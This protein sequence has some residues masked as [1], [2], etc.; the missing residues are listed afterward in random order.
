VWFSAFLYSWKNCVS[1]LYATRSFRFPAFIRRF[2]IES[3]QLCLLAM[4][5]IYNILNLLT[6]RFQILS[7][8][9]TKFIVRRLVWACSL[10]DSGI[11][12][13]YLLS[14]SLY[15]LEALAQW[16]YINTIW[17]NH[18]V[19]F[20][21]FPAHGFRGILLQFTYKEVD[22]D[23]QAKKTS[24]KGHGNEPNFPSF[25]H[26]S[27]WPRSLALLF[28]PF[29]FWLQ[30]RGDIR[31]RKTTPRIGESGSRQDCL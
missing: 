11:L 17:S 21:K 3:H 28:E 6:M 16:L 30:I 26:K 22:I 7:P 18:I 14:F 13:Q 29:R 9:P 19:S 15:I 12:L 2:L 23:I 10:S 24:L 8:L 27:L 25:L 20:Q 4:Y 5:S 31:I 1:F